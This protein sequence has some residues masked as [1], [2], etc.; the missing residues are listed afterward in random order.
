VAAQS[1]LGDGAISAQD[2][3]TIGIQV[4]VGFGIVAAT[5]KQ[6]P[7]TPADSVIRRAG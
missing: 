6:V 3:V 4:L 7:V 2:W 1:A 5:N